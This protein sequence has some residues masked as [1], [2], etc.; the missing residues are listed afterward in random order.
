MRLKVKSMPEDKERRIIKTFLWTPKKI[1]NEWR[2]LEI[3][4][5]GQTYYRK[6]FD[7]GWKSEEWAN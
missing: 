1:K 4:E 5:I 7:W 6:R 3:A 2:W